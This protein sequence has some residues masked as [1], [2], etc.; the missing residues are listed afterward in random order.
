MASAVEYAAIVVVAVG[1]IAWRGRALY[2]YTFH[3]K[4]L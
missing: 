4:N 2:N 3:R 1:L